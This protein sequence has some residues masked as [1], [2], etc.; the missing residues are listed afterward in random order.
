MAT[1]VKQHIIET[2]IS[3]KWRN[4]IKQKKEWRN[5]YNELKRETDSTIKT[6]DDKI[7]AQ[8]SYIAELEEQI[9]QRTE[10]ES[11]IITENNGYITSIVQTSAYNERVSVCEVQGINLLTV[12]KTSAYAKCP[13][14][15]LNDNTI[16]KNKERYK[17]YLII[18]GIV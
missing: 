16:I 3:A 13:F 9:R 1:G 11:Y 7:N 12:T 4:E 2:N 15:E 8:L 14:L 17:K 18:G 6:Q 10:E 5:K